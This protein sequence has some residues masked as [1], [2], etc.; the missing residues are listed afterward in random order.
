MH[1]SSQG[2]HTMSCQEN[3]QGYGDSDAATCLPVLWR[4]GRPLFRAGYAP[5][6]LLIFSF[7][8]SCHLGSIGQEVSNRLAHGANGPQRRILLAGIASD[9]IGILVFDGWSSQNRGC[10]MFW[11]SDSFFRKE[12]RAIENSTN[13]HIPSPIQCVLW[14]ITNR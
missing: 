14:F 5:D 7:S 2:R 11:S 12:I 6:R 4:Y 10:N 13:D 9:Q 1:M 3:D 8:L